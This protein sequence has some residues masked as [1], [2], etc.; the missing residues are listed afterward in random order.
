MRRFTLLLPALVALALLIGW[1]KAHWNDGAVDLPSF[2]PPQAPHFEELH[3]P[4]GPESLH[5]HV[6]DIDGRVV[7]GV[8]LYLRSGGV[9]MWETSDEEGRFAFEG[10][11]TGDVEVVVIAWGHPPR[12][13]M[14][15]PGLEEREIV[16]LPHNPPPAMLNDV[17]YAV[18]GGRVDNPLGA[19]WSDPDGYEVVLVPR[20]PIEEFGG[21]VERRVRCD[22]RGFFLLEDVALGRF[23]AMVLPS[24]A[25]GGSWPDLVAPEYAELEHTREVT[26]SL[27]F[28]LACGAIEASVRDTAG[29]PI[30]GAFVLLVDAAQTLHV[31]PPQTTD[32]LGRFRFIDLPP[33]DYLLQLRAGESQVPDVKVTVR[34]GQVESGLELPPLEVRKRK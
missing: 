11:A 16:L 6:V 3:A 29:K 23:R 2:A 32:A 22:P 7:A 27:V 4:H 14:L 10:L 25:R 9:P 20:A 13:Q 26:E 12:T 5:G 1:W 15:T 8:A 18:L 19:A 17:E 21:A 34:A 28:A 30:E 31:W 33:G 24:W